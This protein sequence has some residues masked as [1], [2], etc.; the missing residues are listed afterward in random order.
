MSGTLRFDGS[1][2]IV[3]GA[4]GYPG[5]GRSYAMLLAER[6]AQVVVNDVGFEKAG[7]GSSDNARAETTARDIVQAGGAAV[8][9]LH[10]VADP[11]G[12]T[13]LVQT[14]IDNFGRLDIVVNNAGVSISDD[15]DKLSEADIRLM[16]DVNLY[17]P[18]WVGRAAWPHLKRS[19]AGRMVNVTSGAFLGMPG[20]VHYGAAKA[21]V[22]GLTRGLAAEAAP[23]GIRVNCVAPAAGSRMSEAMRDDR[24]EYVSMIDQSSK[25]VAPLVAY[26]AHPVCQVTGETFEA[27]FG[28]FRRLFISRTKGLAD[29]RYA[30]ALQQFGRGIVARM[31]GETSESD[32][33]IAAVAQSFEE[34]LADGA[35]A[36]S[37]ELICEAMGLICDP[38]RAATLDAVEAAKLG[39][40]GR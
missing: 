23:L 15:F 28:A 35:P 24:P 20:N 31:A 6:G 9:D 32:K 25:L 16:V 5:L 14:A 34:A 30:R 19:P 1:V 37:P 33:A 4:G 12:A 2:A 27:G 40:A 18:T 26:L 8:A 36:P 13:A 10:S 3:T 22:V 21:A 17:G 29:D 38:D 39:G 11:D 7:R